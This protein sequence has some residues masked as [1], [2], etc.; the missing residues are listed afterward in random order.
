MYRVLRPNGYFICS[1]LGNNHQRLLLKHKEFELLEKNGNLTLCSE[2]GNASLATKL[3][4]SKW[5]IFQTRA[6]IIKNFGSIFQ[7][8]DYIP[9]GQ[10]F[11][12]LHK[13]DATKPIA[14]NSTPFPAG[15]I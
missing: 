13:P 8:V 4:G 12:V 1:V 14:I 5:D 10:D 7:I 2:D 9:G 15:L 3:G 11:L 6:E